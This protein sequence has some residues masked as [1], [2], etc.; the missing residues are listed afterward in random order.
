LGRET[1]AFSVP[2]LDPKAVSA[3]AT[4]EDPMSAVPA[5]ADEAASLVVDRSLELL[6][7]VI[8]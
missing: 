5:P 1:V 8:R 4:D 3:N 2:A 7:N 6:K